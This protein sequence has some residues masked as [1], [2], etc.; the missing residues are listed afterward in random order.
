[1]KTALFGGTFDPV[2]NGHLAIASAAVV[3]GKLDRV[4]FVPCFESPHKS[5]VKSA[6]AAHRFAMLKLATADLPWAEVS[7]WEIQR[8]TP[9]YSWQ[10]AQ[11]FSA[12]DTE[13]FWILGADQWV[14]LERWSKPEVLAALLKFIVFPRDDIELAPKEGFQATFLETRHP[15]S[16]TEIRRLQGVS[17]HLA[18]PVSSYIKQHALYS[19]VRPH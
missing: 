4:V 2:H 18:A 5:G 12:E 15:A 9:S 7:D 1:M 3:Q 8:E 6:D 14:A 11:H 17:P 10:T 16:A 13:L 19:D